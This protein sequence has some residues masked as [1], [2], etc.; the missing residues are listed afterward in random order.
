MASSADEDDW[1]PDFL[2]TLPDGPGVGSPLEPTSWYTHYG[3]TLTDLAEWN[4]ELLRRWRNH[5]DVTQFMVYREHITAEMQLEWFRSLDKERNRYCFISYEKKPIGICHTK[6]I[7]LDAMTGEGGMLIWSK[8]HQNSLVP[9]R[10]ALAGLDWN[11]L[12]L[13]FRAMTVTVL[14]SNRRAIRYNRALGYRFADPDAAGETL[15]GTLTPDDYI[16]AT[17]SVKEV[18]LAEDAA[19]AASAGG[20]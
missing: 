11:F 13:G 19:R 1:D 8:E 17:V 3:V 2:A 20:G 12:K 5:P 4:I 16:A 15:I 9:F 7:D 14:K 18:L 6:N 10:A